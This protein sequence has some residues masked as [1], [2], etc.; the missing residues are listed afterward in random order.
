MRVTQLWRF[1]VKSL[2]GEQIERAEV[3]ELGFDGD[4]RWAIRDS[5]SGRILTA[6]RDGRLLMAS[7]RCTSA[8]GVSIT[9]PSGQETACSDE[10][11]RWLGLDVEL[12]AAGDEGG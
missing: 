6:K 1:P 10:L 8:G 5:S 11:S 9:L 2:G 12:V 3:T 7:A 4:R